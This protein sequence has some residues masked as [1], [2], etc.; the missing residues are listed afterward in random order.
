M[1][2]PLTDQQLAHLLDFIGFGS[3]SGSVW[4]LGMEEAGGGEGNIRTRL[5][6]EPVEDCAL[7]QRELGNSTMHWGKRLIQPTW[8]GMCVIMLRLAGQSPTREAIR[9]YQAEKLG[10][11]GGDTLLT[12]LMPIPKPK[13]VDWPYLELIPQFPSREAYYQTVKPRRIDYLRR[14]VAEQQPPVVI[15][16][17][18]GFWSSYKQVFADLRFSKEGQFEMASDGTTLVLLTDH[19]TARTMNGKFDQVADLIKAHSPTT[20]RGLVTT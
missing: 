15:A 3:L 9:S 8:R 7:A 4:F 2:Q 11:F 16:Y 19:F 18:K 12:E 6:F 10:R 17:G 13:V 5:Q 14:L 20:F 1:T